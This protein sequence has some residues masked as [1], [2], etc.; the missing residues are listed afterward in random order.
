MTAKYASS[1]TQYIHQLLKK[2]RKLK[3]VISLSVKFDL[4]TLINLYFNE[5]F[6]FHDFNMQI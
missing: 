3:N 4:V 6:N 1:N 5:N 2:K